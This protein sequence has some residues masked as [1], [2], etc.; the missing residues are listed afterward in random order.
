M[1]ANVNNIGK[2]LHK[3]EQNCQPCPTSINSSK[4]N[5]FQEL[6]SNKPANW[7]PYI[8]DDWMTNP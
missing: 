4:T 5:C 7:C 6:V 8:T 1:A 3:L 2:T